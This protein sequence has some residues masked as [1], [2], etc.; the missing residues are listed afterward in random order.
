[1]RGSTDSTR[2]RAEWADVHYE[3]YE[4]TKEWG[5]VVSEEA[6]DRT[7]AEE[8]RRLQALAAERG[9]SA[10]G[11]CKALK[12]QQGKFDDSLGHQISTYIDGLDDQLRLLAG[13][14]D[15]EA[16]DAAQE[17]KAMQHLQ[18]V[19]E[20]RFGLEDEEFKRMPDLIMNGLKETLAVRLITTG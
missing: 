15:A 10:K 11:N 1:M 16:G 14:P 7:V 3:D 5:R 17:H 20:G 18:D 12:I 9:L 2:I 13:V 19:I 4:D 6:S 8:E